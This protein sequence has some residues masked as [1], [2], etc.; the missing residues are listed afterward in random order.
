MEVMKD[1]AKSIAAGMVVPKE[2]TCKTC[3]N[4]ES[5]TFKE[6]CFKEYSA[7]VEHLNP[8]KKRTE[9]ELKALRACTCDKCK[10]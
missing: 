4:A 5:P 8:A 3:H 9:E 1:Q 7:K 10:G 6:F 2:E